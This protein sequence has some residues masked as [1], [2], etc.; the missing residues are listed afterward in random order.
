MSLGRSGARNQSPVQVALI[1]QHC[2]STSAELVLFSDSLPPGG[3]AQSHPYMHLD[4]PA[5]L[6]IAVKF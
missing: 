3:T 2:S 4:G 1:L 6:S 5:S